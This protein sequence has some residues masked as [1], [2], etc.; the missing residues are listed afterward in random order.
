MPIHRKA[1]HHSTPL[2]SAIWM[3]W[4][5]NWVS[6]NLASKPKV[7]WIFK[8]ATTTTSMHEIAQTRIW[9]GSSRDYH[10][11]SHLLPTLR[12]DHASWLIEEILVEWWAHGHELVTTKSWETKPLSLVSNK[13]K[14][15]RQ[16]LWRIARSGVNLVSLPPTVIWWAILG[17]KPAW[18]ML[19]QKICLRYTRMVS[20]KAFSLL[21]TICMD[22][23]KIW[24]S[25]YL[26]SLP[27]KVKLLSL[28]LNE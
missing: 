23:L 4:K 10:R 11:Q 26:L 25:S 27:G 12:K 24:K 17:S 9:Q 8:T 7:K 20:C 21:L 1:S 16:K 3:P 19:L 2:P 5:S 18:I 28:W 13:L 6:L 14:T 22:D 15:R